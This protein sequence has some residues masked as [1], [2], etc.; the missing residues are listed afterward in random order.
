[1]VTEKQLRAL[2]LRFKAAP[3]DYGADRLVLVV[4][5]RVKGKARRAFVRRY[6]RRFC[7]CLGYPPRVLVGR[8]VRVL[9]GLHVWAET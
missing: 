9:T 2:G 5:R 8:R 4:P 6:V 3:V 1:M 7:E